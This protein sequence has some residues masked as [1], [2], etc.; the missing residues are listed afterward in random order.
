MDL[1]SVKWL[2]PLGALG[3]TPLA[4]IGPVSVGPSGSEKSSAVIPEVIV[5]VDPIQSV[6]QRKFMLNLQAAKA[7]V[8]FIS[9]F[10]F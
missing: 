6:L 5:K 3:I 8:C 10:T 2:S 4:G 9:M 1:G 7:E